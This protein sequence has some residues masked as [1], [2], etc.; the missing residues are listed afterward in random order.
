MNEIHTDAGPIVRKLVLI[1]VFAYLVG[2]WMVVGGLFA[3]DIVPR[4]R[5][6]GWV[7]GL[8]GAL[9]LLTGWLAFYYGPRWYRRASWVVRTVAPTTMHLKVQIRRDADKSRSLSALLSPVSTDAA[10]PAASLSMQWPS[11]DVESLPEGPVEVFQDPRPGG[12]VVIRTSRGWLWPA[13]GAGFK[14]RGKT[15]RSG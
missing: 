2:G 11:W 10:A 3:P 1:G 12:P 15:G 7:L 14:R 8:I 4:A 5:V 13:P 6:P 9:F